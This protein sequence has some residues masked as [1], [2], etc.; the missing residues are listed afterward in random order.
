VLFHDPAGEALANALLEA[1]GSREA[2]LAQVKDTLR[3]S[4]SRTDALRAWRVLASSDPSSPDARISTALVSSFEPGLPEPPELELH[5]GVWRGQSFR[6]LVADELP[7]G[8]HRTLARLWHCAG[9]IPRFRSQLGGFG[10]SERDKL[11]RL[12]VS[13]LAETYAHAAR[14]LGATDI[15]IYASATADELA[16]VLPTHPPSVLTSRSTSAR[17]STLAYV[18]GR[19]LVLAGPAR[20]IGGALLSSDARELLDA[21]RLAF[22]PSTLESDVTGSSKELAAA[23]WQSIPAGEQ[24]ELSDTF[25]HHAELLRY[26]TLRDSSRACAA[27]GALACS[28]SVLAALRHLPAVEESLHGLDLGHEAELAEGCRRSP[29]LAA[30]IVAA[31]SSELLEAVGKAR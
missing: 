13:S 5:S 17:R 6:D 29:A 19:A 10:L 2:A 22:A 3:K 15:P 31:V 16:R 26:E 9:L 8:V 30:T 24:R 14:L 1:Q 27:R 23:L 4:P 25:K 21:A 7:E 28:G 11:S 20:F 18:L 12:T